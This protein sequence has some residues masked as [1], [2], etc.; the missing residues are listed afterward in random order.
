MEPQIE[1]GE[2]VDDVRM[3]LAA[4][5]SPASRRATLALFPSSDMVVSFH[6][7][8]NVIGAHAPGDALKT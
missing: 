2:I 1:R 3:E 5:H 6:Q 8:V 4:P 7:W